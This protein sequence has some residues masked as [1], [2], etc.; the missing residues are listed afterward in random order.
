MLRQLEITARS[1]SALAST[2]GEKNPYRY[3]GYRYDTNTGLFYVGS[4]YYDPQIGRFLNADSQLNPGTGLV[5]MNM[6]AYCNNNPVML[7][8]SDGT[9]SFLAITAIVG[10]VVGAVAGGIIAAKTGNNIWAG[11][12]IG[13][14]GGILLGLG[15]GAGLAMISGAGAMATAG[16]VIAGLGTVAATQADKISQ[17]I[18]SGS[19][20]INQGAS[21]AANA[22]ELNSNF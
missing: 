14:A 7:T 17:A 15:V 2:V 18:Q 21:N 11:I 1:C 19:S 12:G 22:V 4:Q 8:D 20:K 6:F 9:I 13:A 3:R 10:A 16:E 5:G